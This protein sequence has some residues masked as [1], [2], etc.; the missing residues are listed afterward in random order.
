MLLLVKIGLLLL[1]VIE[2]QLIEKFKEKGAFT[3][4]ELLYFSGHTTHQ[5]QPNPLT[6]LSWATGEWQALRL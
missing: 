1:K 2:N 3:K 6:C 5:C 4:E